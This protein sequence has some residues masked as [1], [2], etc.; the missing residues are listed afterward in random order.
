MKVNSSIAVVEHDGVTDN[1]NFRIKFDAKMANILASGLYSDKIK[2]IIR[3]LSCNAA[4]AHLAA[5]NTQP[6]EVHLPNTFEPFFHVKDFGTGLSHEQVMDIYTT[7]G[8][9]TKTNSNDFIGQLGLGSKSPFSYGNDVA[10]T[11]SSRYNGTENHYSMFRDETGMPSSALLGSNPTSEPNGV[12]VTMPVKR[13]D[14]NQFSEKAI[15]VFKWFETKPV[16]TGAS[17]RYPAEPKPV[18][19]GNDWKILS[20]TNDGYGY[21]N[22]YN[23]DIPLAIMGKIAYPLTASSIPNLPRHLQ[24][25]L[26]FSLV[27]KFN[28]G[29][30]DIAASREEL[31]YDKRTC[32]TITRKLELIYRDLKSQFEK[33]FVDCKTLWDAK[34]LYSQ[35]FSNYDGQS[36]RNLFVNNTNPLKWNGIVLDC[37]HVNIEFSKIYN[38][39]IKVESIDPTTG[40]TVVKIINEIEFWETNMYSRKMVKCRYD[41]AWHVIPARNPTIIFNDLVKKNALQRIEAY[42]KGL[43]D[44]TVLS[45]FGP[46]PKMTWDQL[47]DYLGNP[48]VIFAS[49]LPELPKK[50]NTTPST[51]VLVWDQNY[52]PSSYSAKDSAW[53]KVLLSDSELEAGGFYVRLRGY[54]VTNL[55]SKTIVKDADG[56]DKEE[57]NYENIEDFK[58]LYQYAVNA[59][60]IAKDTK[61]YAGRRH[62]S[63]KLVKHPKWIDLIEYMKEKTNEYVN[64]N[65]K[66]IASCKSMASLRTSTKINV[67]LTPRDWKCADGSVFG[68]FINTIN[69]TKKFYN[70]SVMGYIEIMKEL[71][72]CS[73]LDKVEGANLAKLYHTV[74]STYPMLRLIDPNAINNH[75]AL[76]EYINLVDNQKTV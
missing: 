67:Y 43:A 65:K 24:Q 17:I 5:G 22:R 41:T 8:E 28:I 54:T 57:L 58:S 52:N 44:R 62:I 12:T 64:T 51:E 39:D 45:V 19:E 33:K 29:D 59:G 15:Q 14:I 31:G 50:E 11:V 2:S 46:S 25:L 13:D 48:P 42:G 32:A 27:V 6:F 23:H 18:F 73:D 20:R 10:F 55:V 71:N 7:Y 4:D 30:L 47:K 72:I 75:R 53:D 38:T 69:E 49:T 56:K 66:M 63:A 74:E 70:V 60:I 9:S 16:I 34:I 68:N 61:I 76:N 40:K 36:L 21:Y 37:D 26:G 1:K 3:E 35:L